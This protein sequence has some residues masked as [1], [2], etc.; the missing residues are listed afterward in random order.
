G[1]STSGTIEVVKQNFCGGTPRTTSGVHSV[2]SSCDGLLDALCSDAASV[3]TVGAASYNCLLDTTTNVVAARVGFCETP[4]KTY[5]TGCT[6]AIGNV[7][8]VRRQLALSCSGAGS[9]GNGC[10]QLITATGTITVATCSAN[11]FL[12]TDGCN[13]DTGFDTERTTRRALCTTAGATFAPFDSKCNPA[14]ATDATYLSDVA[15]AR[16]SYC[17]DT[18]GF[19]HVECRTT[20]RTATICTDTDATTLATKPFATLCG[21]NDGSTATDAQEAACRLSSDA[22]GNNCANTIAVFCGSPT[23][24][25]STTANLF[26]TALCDNTFDIARGRACLDGYKVSGVAPTLC[27]DE[28]TSGNYIYAYCQ[29]AGITNLADCPATYATMNGDAA[30]VSVA[31]FK[32]SGQ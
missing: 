12:T 19:D 3:T 20:G 6:T 23:S 7:L 16:D 24:P 14:T 21:G 17:A 27:G 11:P 2:H 10:G 13:T 25:S 30:E 18:A 1:T 29:D 32:A 9:G 31:A 22:D 15:T 5:T 4:D 26:D 28:N 8:D